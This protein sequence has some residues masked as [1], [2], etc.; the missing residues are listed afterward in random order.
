MRS[1]DAHSEFEITEQPLPATG[2]D[3]NSDAPLAVIERDARDLLRETGR[4]RSRAQEQERT[5]GKRERE[6]LLELVAVVD[7]FERVFRNLADR[8]QEMDRRAKIWIGN[9]RTVYRLVRRT[10]E[11]GGVVP[12]EVLDN[13]FDPRWHQVARAVR[14]DSQPTGT[15]IE[16]VDRGYFLGDTVLRKASVVVVSDEATDGSLVEAEK[17]S[18]EATENGDAGTDGPPQNS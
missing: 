17:T 16:E 10:L 6:L 13:S 18:A 8:Q 4:L 5:S 3:G 7:A 1:S 12:M 11:D 14:D 15:I 2:W 9:F